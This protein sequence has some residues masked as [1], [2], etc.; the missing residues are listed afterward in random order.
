MSYGIGVSKQELKSVLTVKFRAE[1]F[2]DPGEVADFAIQA[3]EGIGLEFYS[4]DT[5][6]KQPILRAMY[7]DCK[8]S[9]YPNCCSDHL[10]S[11]YNCPG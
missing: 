5:P 4:E 8:G 10:D 2:D 7:S 3:M 1:K 9:G 11:Y 6:S